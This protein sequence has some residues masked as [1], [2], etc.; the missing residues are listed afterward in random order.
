MKRKKRRKLYCSQNWRGIVFEDDS[1]GLN[2][3][4]RDNIET[5]G[6]NAGYIVLG[7]VFIGVL[8]DV[9]EGHRLSKRV[10]LNGDNAYLSEFFAGNLDKFLRSV[11]ILDKNRV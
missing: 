5:T 10:F 2:E 6:L 4:C 7:D 3:K 9:F 8:G 11:T 1:F